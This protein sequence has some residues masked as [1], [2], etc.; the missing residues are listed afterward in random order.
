MLETVREY[1]RE[2]LDAEEDAPQTHERH[3]RHYLALA[4]RA[5]PELFTRGEARWLPRLDAE[6]HNLR[7]ALD[8]SVRHG[9]PG[10]A[11]RL[12]GLLSKFWEIRN[13]PDEGLEWI[14]ASLDAAG[15]A[16]PLP[17]R[18]RA[19]RA[20]ALLLAVKG[21]AY[22]A[23]GL[24][25]EARAKAAE[26][27]DL[28]RQVGEP[29]GIADAL[30]VLAG[31]ETAESSPQQRRRALAEEALS[32]ASQAGDDRLVAVAL[33]ERALAVPL[34]QERRTSSRRRRRYARSAA[35]ATSSGCTPAP[36]TTRSRRAPRSE[37]VHCSTGR[38]RS[39]VSL[40]IRCCWPSCGATWA[41]RRS[42]PVTSTG[43]AARL[44]SSFDCAESTCS[45]WAQRA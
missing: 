13:L 38:S 26:A 18:A 16:A 34:E 29:A 21:A 24:M 28:S 42:S 11:L 5:E 4:E 15:D 12:A 20:Q 9:D 36:P 33:T 32:C 39:R 17:D 8:W 37:R 45:G 7:A 40:E 31:I 25:R 43:H 30:L 27:L 23:H 6:V 44:T 41:L 14:E 22:D 1:A 35:R 2:R 19:R 10:S 3:C